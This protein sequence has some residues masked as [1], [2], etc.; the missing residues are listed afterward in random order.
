MARITRRG[1]VGFAV[2]APYLT[3]QAWAQ[4]SYPD[5]PV[6]MIVPCS[7]GG[8]ADTIAR[9]IQPKVAENLGQSFI[10]ENRTGASGSIGAMAVAPSP[11]D[12][13]TFLFEGASFATLPLVSRSLVAAIYHALKDPAIQARL[14][15][16]GADPVIS[17]PVA[18]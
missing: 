16:T 13:H 11:A 17:S 3:R 9:I 14:E 4:G 7:A 2:A 1:L 12:G 6:R 15:A 18:Y 5:R 8:V 10:I